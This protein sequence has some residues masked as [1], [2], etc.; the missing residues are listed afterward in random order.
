MGDAGQC[1]IELGGS[2]RTP[3]V[4][5]AAVEG[6]R[7]FLQHTRSRASSQHCTH[8]HTC[9]PNGKNTRSRAPAQHCR[10]TSQM[11]RTPVHLSALHT[12]QPD[13]KNTF[14]RTLHAPGQRCTC[15]P[16]G[17]NTFTRTLHAPGQGCTCQP[18]GKNTRSRAPAQHC[19]GTNAQM[20]RTPVHVRPLS[21]AHMPAKW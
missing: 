10:H 21:T 5:F 20:V 2:I 3:F 14:T 12:C 6:S 9:Q 17:K 7:P 16:D 8:A 18:N 1:V 13:G 19:R 11:A 15:Q 4:P